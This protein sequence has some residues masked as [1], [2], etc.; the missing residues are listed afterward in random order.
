M[1]FRLDMAV[2]MHGIHADFD[3]LDLDTRS[4]IRVDRQRK[5]K[6]NP[7]GIQTRHDGRCVHDIYI[8]MF[9]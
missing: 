8:L 4:K 2:D 1:A 5:T 7:Y 9:V 6:L 3:D